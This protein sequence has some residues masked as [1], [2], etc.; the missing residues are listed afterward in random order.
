MPLPAQV[1]SRPS[2]PWALQ[3]FLLSSLLILL[4]SYLPQLMAIRQV[5]VAQQAEAAQRVEVVQQVVVILQVRLIQQV[6]VL[7]PR[8][9]LLRL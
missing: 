7:P 5:V 2:Q 4:L 1:L 3:L 9:K 6:E 8:V